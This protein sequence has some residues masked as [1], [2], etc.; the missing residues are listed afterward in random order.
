MLGIAKNEGVFSERD[1]NDVKAYLQS[2]HRE[3]TRPYEP[4]DPQSIRPNFNKTKEEEGLDEET[5]PLNEASVS[6]KRKKKKKSL[7]F[8]PCT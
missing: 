5:N 6:F 2:K 4:K 3:S 8:S 7:F 1:L